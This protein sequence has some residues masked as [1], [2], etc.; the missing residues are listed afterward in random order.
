MSID[1]D[2]AVSRSLEELTRF[3]VMTSPPRLEHVIRDYYNISFDCREA[4]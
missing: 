4:F 3:V 1:P 2:E